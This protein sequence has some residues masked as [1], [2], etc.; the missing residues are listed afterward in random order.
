MMETISKPIK[1]RY[2]HADPPSLFLVSWEAVGFNCVFLFLILHLMLFVP[3]VMF[4]QFKWLFTKDLNP[5]ASETPKA[6][7]SSHVFVT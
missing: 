4:I 3:E 6:C 2:C 5:R 7:F 1:D